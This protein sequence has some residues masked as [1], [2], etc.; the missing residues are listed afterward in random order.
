MAILVN[1]VALA[2]EIATLSTRAAEYAWT[3]II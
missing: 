2:Q 3:L 1:S